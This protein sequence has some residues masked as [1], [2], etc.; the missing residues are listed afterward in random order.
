[1]GLLLKTQSTLGVEAV[2]GE[3]VE[4]AMVREQELW[5]LLTAVVVAVAE[6]RPEELGLLDSAGLSGLNRK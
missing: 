6:I 5:E 1:V 2:H 3:K 4:M